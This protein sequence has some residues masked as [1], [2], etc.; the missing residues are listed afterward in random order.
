MRTNMKVSYTGSFWGIL[1]S[2]SDNS[3]RSIRIPILIDAHWSK[4]E[5]G[6]EGRS[7]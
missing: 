1:N 2:L 4:F 6:G 7:D 5:V 3:P